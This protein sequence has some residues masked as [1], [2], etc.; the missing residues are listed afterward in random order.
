M[1]DAWKLSASELLSSYEKG[2]LSPVE[3]VNSCLDRITSLDHEIGAF[4]AL[5]HEEAHR[6]ARQAE[7]EIMTN[8]LQTPLHGV[9]V[10]VK[11][12]FDVAGSET[13]WGS[14]IFSGRIPEKD[15][16]AVEAI[17][18]AGGILLGLTRS[19]EFA[20]GI[21]TQH[22]V[23]GGTKNPWN[24]G[25]VP[26]GSSGGSSAAV[27][28]GMGPV[29]LG[30]DTGGSL[31][32]PAAFCGINAIKP[33]FGAVELSGVCPL[34]PGLDHAGPLARTIKDCALVLS[35]ISGIE[36]PRWH[37]DMKGT[38]VVISPDLAPAIA[39][40]NH[41]RAFQRALK[42]VE[43]L[44]ARVE[45]RAFRNSSSFHKTFT[46]LQRY[47]ALR[48]HADVLGTYPS[49]ASEYSASVRRNLE[50]AL[51]I[52]SDQYL[53]AKQ[54]QLSL[55]TDFAALLENADILMTP[56]APASP[57]TILDPDVAVI[58]GQRLPLR[59][60]VMGHTILQNL[61]GA[62]AAVVNVGF[63]VFGLPIGVQLTAAVGDDEP[64]M[65]A[66]DVFQE[67]AGDERPW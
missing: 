19:H 14:T 4:T 63:D 58:D 40:L 3:A 11:E 52:T 59:D 64:L 45:E 30:T 17:K 66:A 25:R 26:G 41:L 7:H 49:R 16:G 67:A 62:P 38:R 34:A 6:A 54:E 51:T 43:D 21:T 31:R 22:E 18:R 55:R 44:G 61:V 57:P 27:A 50:A 36:I 28:A 1:T 13:T 29:A 32:I 35:T 47:E 10:A 15:S 12:L 2:A 48:I 23:R 65:I 33:T 24:P 39:D 9:P 46:I 20:W 42:L 37:D 60:V 53:K 5:R 8:G 56:V